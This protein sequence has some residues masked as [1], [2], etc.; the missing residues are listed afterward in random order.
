MNADDKKVKVY[1]FD[2]ET[3]ELSNFREIAYPDDGDY[4]R[5]L[6]FSPN[7]RF[8][9]VT[10]VSN[11][12]Q[13]DLQDNSV[14]HI[15]YH[16]SVDEDNWPVTIGYMLNGPDC[17]VYLDAGST[18]YYIHAIHQPNEKG[19]NCLFQ[20]R[21]LRLPANQNHEFPNLPMYRF[22]GAC[23]SSIV[24]PV[25]AVGEAMAMGGDV[26]MVYPNPVASELN[27]QLSSFS[28]SEWASIKIFNAYGKLVKY[29]KE[30][31]SDSFSISVED[32]VPG[33]YFLQYLE[34]GEVR[35]VE[36]LI[37]QR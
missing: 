12:Y 22:D 35:A 1:D 28:K 4:A 14:D 26:I 18:T 5:G 10:S 2:N 27:I 9:Y 21:A 15:A 20:A 13:I 11:L 7:S 37:V 17:R 16:L 3:G 36:K 6:V 33:I 19:L 8:I 29:V 34:A 31:D 23:D 32:F 24:F 25:S 30:I